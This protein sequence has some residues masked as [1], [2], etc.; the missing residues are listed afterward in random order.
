MYIFFSEIINI[1]ITISVLTNGRTVY[2]SIFVTKIQLK[3]QIF[4][5][6]FYWT[7]KRVDYAIIELG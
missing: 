1:T 4:Q 2:N 3:T 5:K 7:N 6:D